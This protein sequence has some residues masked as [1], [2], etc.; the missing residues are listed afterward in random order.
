MQE[1]SKN[2]TAVSCEHSTHL[3]PLTN[4]NFWQTFFCCGSS[5]F[6]HF[7]FLCL[8]YPFLGSISSSLPYQPLLVEISWKCTDHST[9]PLRMKL[10]EFWTENI[11][12]AKM[13]LPRL[14]YH[15]Q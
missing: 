6:I 11:K 15:N 12:K 5:S 4:R 8:G 9:P 2:R 13:E 1:L 10:N 3:N 7:S 14:S